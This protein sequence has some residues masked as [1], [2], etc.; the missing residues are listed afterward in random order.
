MLCGLTTIVPGFAAMFIV[1]VALFESCQKFT[2]PAVLVNWY[3]VSVPLPMMVG[4]V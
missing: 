4:A 2:V 3:S 1:R